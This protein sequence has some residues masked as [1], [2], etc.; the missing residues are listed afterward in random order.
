[1]KGSGTR[2]FVEPECYEESPSP[3]Q[4]QL[5]VTSPGEVK[6]RLIWAELHHQRDQ[7]G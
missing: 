2:T 5:V 7:Q 1:M 4:V 6:A 3:V